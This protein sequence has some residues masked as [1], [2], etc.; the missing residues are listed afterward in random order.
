MESSLR[1]PEKTLYT[2]IQ[3]REL[4]STLYATCPD[5]AILSS[6]KAVTRLSDI[7]TRR[8]TAMSDAEVVVD[9]LQLRNNFQRLHSIPYDNDTTLC[10]RKIMLYR[11][12]AWLRERHIALL[13]TYD[14]IDDF[15]NEPVPFAGYALKKAILENFLEKKQYGSDYALTVTLK[16]KDFL[17]SY[18]REEQIIALLNKKVVEQAIQ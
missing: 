18:A 6:E 5:D 7:V 13:Q 3:D 2:Y 8:Y 14:V 1:I 4:L 9:S 15:S 16:N 11:M 12:Q 17:Q 10:L